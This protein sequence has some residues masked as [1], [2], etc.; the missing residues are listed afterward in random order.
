[1][2]ALVPEQALRQCHDRMM[3]AAAHSWS[4]RKLLI[5]L[6]EF[7]VRIFSETGSFAFA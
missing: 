1:V 5:W 4:G 2:L 3:T 6:K 7:E